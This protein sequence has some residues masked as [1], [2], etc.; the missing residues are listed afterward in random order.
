MQDYVCS[1]VQIE[2]ELVG[3]ELVAGHPVGF[4]SVLE[5]GDHLPH[6]YSVTIALRVD[7]A[8]PLPLKSVT[9]YLTFV[10]RLL[11]S[12]LTTTLC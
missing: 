7:E 5:L 9:T 12:I 1:A 3:R 11:T 4:E 6:A 8:G 2:S 10:P